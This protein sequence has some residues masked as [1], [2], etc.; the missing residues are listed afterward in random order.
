MPKVDPATGRRVRRYVSLKIQPER[1]RA[2]LRWLEDGG[3]PDWPVPAEVGW[4]R[5]QITDG[6]RYLERTATAVVSQRTFEA[7]GGQARPVP[8]PLWPDELEELHRLLRR[9]SLPT[10]SPAE[11]ILG[12]LEHLRAL[13][14]RQAAG[15]LTPPGGGILRQRGAQ[16]QIPGA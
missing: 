9:A 2:I 13:P 16:R 12:R 8:V 1:A 7:G 11:R 14:A 5:A 4:L 6:L 10:G 15:A 3:P